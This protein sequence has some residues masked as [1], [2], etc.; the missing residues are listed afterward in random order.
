[1]MAEGFINLFFLITL[2]ALNGPHRCKI[3]TMPK[4]YPDIKNLAGQ[5]FYSAGPIQLTIIMRH[6]LI[7]LVNSGLV[8]ILTSLAMTLINSTLTLDHWLPNWLVSWFIVC[9]YVYW[10]APKVSAQISTMVGR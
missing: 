5:I 6:F 7:S 2:T 3:T 8:T 10:L 1:M 4:K 9:N